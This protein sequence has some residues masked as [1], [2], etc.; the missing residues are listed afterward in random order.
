MEKSIE[1]FLRT[2]GFSKSTQK[3]YRWY[4]NHLL[5]AD[6]RDPQGWDAVDLADWLDEHQTWGANMRYLAAMA[7]KGF[8]KWLWGED[9]PVTELVIKKAKTPPGRSLNDRLASYFR[10]SFRSMVG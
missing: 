10:S 9:H 4:L 2:N 5:L 3:T 6:G 1:R 8:C 7:V